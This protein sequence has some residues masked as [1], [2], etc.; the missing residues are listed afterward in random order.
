MNPTDEPNLDVRSLRVFLC[1]LEEGSVS[2]AARRLGV[3]QSAVSHTLDRLRD[4]LGDPLFVKA[5]RGIVPTRHAL[6]TGDRVRHLLDDLHGLV[7]DNAFDPSTLQATF[8]IAAND[9]QRDLLLPGLFRALSVQAPGL[10]LRVIPSGIPSADLLRKDRC[11]LILTPHPPQAGDILQRRLL[12]EQMVVFYD[13]ACRSAPADV[14]DFLHSRHITIQFGA[15]ERMSLDDTLQA[16]DLKRQVVVTVSNFSGVA[17]FLRGSDLLAT[18]PA[19]L[20]NGIMQGFAQAPVPLTLHPFVLYMLWHQRHQ[21][22]PAHR[23]I[24]GHL[25]R[26]A[27]EV[28][29]APLTLG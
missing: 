5:G 18:L 9:Y 1:V 8:T 28:A 24:R 10:C 2:A 27:Q 7:A 17:P 3:T 15:G 25:L 19:R 29:P 11:D 14:D 12:D 22:D 26:I 21:Q 16:Q 20:A 6:Q 13:P 4:A 23:W